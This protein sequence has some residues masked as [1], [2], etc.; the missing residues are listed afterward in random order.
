MGGRTN[1]GLIYFFPRDSKWTKWRGYVMKF[2]T[3]Y[4]Q[5]KACFRVLSLP[6]YYTGVIVFFSTSQQVI[7]LIACPMCC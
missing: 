2:Y 3:S 1:I 6:R 7:G 4:H 5:I